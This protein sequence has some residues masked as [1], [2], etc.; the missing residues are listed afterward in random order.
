M[1][2]YKVTYQSMSA[3]YGPTFVEADDEY[4]A[5]VKF[6]GNAFSR[7]EFGLIK[8]RESSLKE[9]RQAASSR[10]DD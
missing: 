6:A 2:I 4:S 1:A 3:F 9:M 8:A 10:E 7:S 5:K